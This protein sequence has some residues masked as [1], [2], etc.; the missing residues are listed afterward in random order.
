[1]ILAAH[2]PQ[3]LPWLGYFDKMR[4]ADV[5]VLL[6]DVQ[7]K[8]N[9]WQNRNS[10]WSRQGPQWL[11]VPCLQ[12]FPQEVRAVEI[13]NTVAW[14][15]KQERT[16]KQTYAKARHFERYWKPWQDMYARFWDRLLDLNLYTI[17]TLAAA[18]GVTTRRELSSALG[19]EGN[20]TARLVEICRKLGAD[21]YLAGSGGRAY[22]ELELFERAGIKVVFQDYVHP[23]YPQ[24]S[25]PFLPNLSAIDLL[26][27]CGSE[28]AKILPG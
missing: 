24:F 13:N 19:V 8:K 27:H 25:G 10:I 15:L 3:F 1:M 22:M 6:D 28:A 11:T 5:F 14:R 4:R 17:E 2:Q 20:A 23:Q 7:F 12:Q 16:L 9:E 26:F 21:V 18:L